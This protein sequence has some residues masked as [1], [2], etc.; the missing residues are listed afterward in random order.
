MKI[1][2]SETTPLQ[3]NWLVANPGKVSKY[4]SLADRIH[5][6]STP[7]TNGCR[8]WNGKKNQHG[9]AVCKVDGKQSRA[10]RALYFLLNPDADRSLVVMHT[11]DNPACVNPAHL[12]LGT[13]R[14][15]MLDMVN[16]GR[17]NGG[18][19]KG[20]KN[21]VGNE[22]WKKGGVTAKY[23]ASKLGDEVD[24]PEELLGGTK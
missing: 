5:R 2:T 10:H 6:Q 19:P 17:H 15:N 1:K 3:L 11:C 22:G 7:D 12:K 13:V 24:V 23:A 14:D 4:T 16:K 9:Y 18:A 20:N 21:A 8:I